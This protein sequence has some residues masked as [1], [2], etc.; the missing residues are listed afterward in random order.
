MEL[1]PAFG[2]IGPRRPAQALAVLGKYGVSGKIWF[3]RQK[4]AEM[5]KSGNSALYGRGGAAGVKLFTLHLF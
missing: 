3:F 2:R 1:G 4:M 5:V